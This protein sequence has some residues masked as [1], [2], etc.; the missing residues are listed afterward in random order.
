VIRS[1]PLV[2]L[3]VSLSALADNLPD[4]PSAM[5]SPAPAPVVAVRPA[6]VT[7]EVRPKHRVATPEFLV[8]AVTA[9]AATIA[10]IE[11]TMWALKN[12]RTC[13]ETNPIYGRNPSRAKMYAINAPINMA[14]LWLSKYLKTHTCSA[15]GTVCWAWRIPFVT[16][17]IAHGAAAAHNFRV[18]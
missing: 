9:N 2:V 14:S 7:T 16:L 8:W 5:A 18:P 12:C 11:S 17:S 10:D 15:S 4:A 1:L 6:A 3:L 13:R